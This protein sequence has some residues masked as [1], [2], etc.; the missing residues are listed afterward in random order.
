[1]NINTLKEFSNLIPLADAANVLGGP[2]GE[3]SYFN[4]KTNV[5]LVADKVQMMV[6]QNQNILDSNNFMNEAV[7]LVYSK[8]LIILTEACEMI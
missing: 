1:M 7:L 4:L 2:Q 3:L 8:L 6:I 5:S